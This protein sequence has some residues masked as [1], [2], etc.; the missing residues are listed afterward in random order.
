MERIEPT[1]GSPGS[2][3][4]APADTPPPPTSNQQL[5]PT[6]TPERNAGS[7]SMIAIEIRA[8]SEKKSILVAYLLWFFLGSLGAH[9]FYIARKGI[10]VFEL[11]LGLYY[12]AIWLTIGLPFALAFLMVSLQHETAAE[13]RPYAASASLVISLPVMILGLF[14]IVDLFRIPAR[15]ARHSSLLRERLVREAHFRK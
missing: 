14:L 11:L 7:D 6:P 12:W 4:A 15:I 1:L 13:G 8:T 10:A 3:A 9:N 2:W 5:A